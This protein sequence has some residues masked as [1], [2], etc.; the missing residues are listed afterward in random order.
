MSLPRLFGSSERCFIGF[1]TDSGIVGIR[2]AE[3]A[4]TKQRRKDVRGGGVF[5]I[6]NPPH[7]DANEMAADVPQL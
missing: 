7:R 3:S 6:N 1:T 5:S 2:G 4:T